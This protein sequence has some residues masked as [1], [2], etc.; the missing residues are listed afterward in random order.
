M[1]DSRI[2]LKLLDIAEDFI[3]FLGVDWVKPDDIIMTGSLANFNWNKKYSDIDLH[4]LIDFSKVDKRT[5]F[6]KKYFDSLKNQW[7]EVH[8]DL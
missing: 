8:E 7:N 2:R 4:V 3:D 5:D 6:V 1:L